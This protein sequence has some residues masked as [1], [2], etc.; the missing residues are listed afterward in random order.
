MTHP[1]NPDWIIAPAETF[2]EWLDDM[3]VTVTNVAAREQPPPSREAVE[4]LLGEV[5]ARKPLHDAHARA[6]MRA[7]GIPVRFWLN[8][9]QAYRAGLA[10]G[11]KDTTDVPHLGCNSARAKAGDAYCE[12]HEVRHHA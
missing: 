6:L 9:E 2:Q 10:A 4:A 12:T 11:L 1:F 5:L 3:G 8:M 7:T